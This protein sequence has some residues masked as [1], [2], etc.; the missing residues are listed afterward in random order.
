MS[1]ET[2]STT[3]TIEALARV[4]HF[5]KYPITLSSNP[6]IISN[7]L[8]RVALKEKGFF[9]R[10]LGDKVSEF[11][12][13]ALDEKQFLC[14]AYYP[15]LST[16]ELIIGHSPEYTLKNKSNLLIHNKTQN[17]IYIASSETKKILHVLN[18]SPDLIIGFYIE[19]NKIIVNH[20]STEHFLITYS[21]ENGKVLECK[22]APEEWPLGD[23]KDIFMKYKN[24]YVALKI[25]LK[26]NEMVIFF[27]NGIHFKKL[28]GGPFLDNEYMRKKFYYALLSGKSFIFEMH[29]VSDL[30]LL[31][32]D[33][34]SEVVFGGDIMRVKKNIFQFHWNLNCPELEIAP[35]KTF[36]FH[37][38]DDY[39]YYPLPNEGYNNAYYSMYPGPT[40]NPAIFKTNQG[41]FVSIGE[42]TKLFKV[43]RNTMDDNV[44]EEVLCC[45]KIM[46][47]I[48]ITYEKDSSYHIYEITFDG[49]EYRGKI[50]F[51][52]QTLTLETSCFPK[53]EEVHWNSSLKLLSLHFNGRPHLFHLDVKN[54][55][56]LP[57]LYYHP[58]D[59][60]ISA[61]LGTK[62][63]VPA[64][65]PNKLH[66]KT[67][68]IQTDVWINIFKQL[69]YHDRLM[70]SQASKLFYLIAHAER[71]NH[72]FGKLLTTTDID[73]L[74]NVVSGCP[75][76][77]PPKFQLKPSKNSPYLV[78]LGLFAGSKMETHDY[79]VK[80]L[81]RLTY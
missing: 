48:A 59:I 73:I 3:P 65:Q 77:A 45:I 68:L 76:E 22:K 49:F 35:Q 15:P 25:F 27:Y 66:E 37:E 51:A 20:N 21:L 47:E 80:H 39:I 56:I 79:P 38:G 11:N 12:A 53:H 32:L 50:P 18:A 63:T 81:E 57:I 36:E 1:H 26:K 55:F 2:P 61:F 58:D 23:T 78:S 69:S 64:V 16:E 8:N 33:E 52:E 6:L 71:I 5:T 42:Y 44:L 4:S 28:V 70:F 31:Y 54:N 67:N 24:G 34:F 75:K 41:L 46:D 14:E 7:V 10:Y 72:H 62:E 74:R 17:C 19:Q 40:A 60:F 29:S 30:K 43:P 9:P 13:I